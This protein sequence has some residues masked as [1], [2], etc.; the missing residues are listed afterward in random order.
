MLSL[1]T[2]RR[3]HAIKNRYGFSLWDA[4]IVASALEAGCALLYTEDLQHG[5]WIE[6]TLRIENPFFGMTA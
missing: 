5:Q 2:I 4:L 1:E 3:A 6:Q